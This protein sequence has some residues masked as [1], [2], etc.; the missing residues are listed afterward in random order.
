[1]EVA[2]SI[3]SAS[4]KEASSQLQGP[5]NPERL[6]AL[7]DHREGKLPD[8]ALSELAAQTIDLLH[9]VEQLLEPSSLV[10]ADHFLGV[11]QSQVLC[12]GCAANTSRLSQLQMPVCGSQVPHSRFPR[13][14][15]ANPPKASPAVRSQRGSTAPGPPDAVQQR[16][17]CLLGRR[18]HVQQ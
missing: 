11:Y 16:N 15:V 1:M 4:L 6:A 10:L 14:W 3:L 9:Q 7:H 2:L 12:Y 13:R 5:L 8:A 17:L 18:R